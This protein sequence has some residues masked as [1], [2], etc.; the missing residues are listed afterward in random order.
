MYQKS[1]GGLEIIGLFLI[2][3][4]RS[5]PGIAKLA[6]TVQTF[7]FLRPTLNVLNYEFNKIKN[8]IKQESIKKSKNILF[9]KNIKFSNVSFF[10]N[11]K[12]KLISNLSLQIKKGSKIGVIGESGFGKSTFLL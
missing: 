8:D 1:D 11:R 7:V 6:S 4:F 3:V 5:M 2:V 10:Y 9:K 12:N